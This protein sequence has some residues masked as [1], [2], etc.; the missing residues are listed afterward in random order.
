MHLGW[1]RAKVRRKKNLTLV[2]RAQSQ[3]AM[4]PLAVVV[5]LAGMA[6]LAQRWGK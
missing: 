6:T 1:G 2:G 5:M 4:S 3:E